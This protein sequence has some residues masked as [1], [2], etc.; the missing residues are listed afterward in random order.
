MYN[1]ITTVSHEKLPTLTTL[2]LAAVIVTVPA[3]LF[4][5]SPAEDEPGY[6][7]ATQ[8]HKH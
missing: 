8:T 5:R 7:K 6:N 4:K 1:Y 3:D 2:H